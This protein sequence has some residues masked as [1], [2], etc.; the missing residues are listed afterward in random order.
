MNNDGPYITIKQAC[1]YLHISERTLRTLIANRKIPYYRYSYQFMFKIG[2]LEEWVQKHK[3]DES[4]PEP[5]KCPA[6]G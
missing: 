1:K 3:V 5:F 4:D 2:D 6:I